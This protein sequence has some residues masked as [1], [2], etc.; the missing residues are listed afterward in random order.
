MIPVLVVAGKNTKNAVKLRRTR[1]FEDD[2]STEWPRCMEGRERA[3]R[4]TTAFWRVIDEAATRHQ[5]DV[6]LLDVGPNLGVIN[7]AAL[8]VHPAMW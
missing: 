5:A 8:V 7:R 4:V 6:V 3:F 1:S 2:L